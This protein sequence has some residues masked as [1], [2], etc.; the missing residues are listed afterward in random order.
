MLPGTDRAR[1]VEGGRGPG[2]P[3]MADGD[4]LIFQSMGEGPVALR[5]MWELTGPDELRWRNEVACGG[6]P[7]SPVEEYRLTLDPAP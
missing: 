3:E 5:L 4:R 6:G 2:T 1:I 7:W